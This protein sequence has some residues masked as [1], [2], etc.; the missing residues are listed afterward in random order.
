MSPAAQAQAIFLNVSNADKS[1]LALPVAASRQHLPGGVQVLKIQRPPPH[2]PLREFMREELKLAGLRLDAT[3]F[4]R[5]RMGHSLAISL[6][7]R[8]HGPKPFSD[9]G[10]SSGVADVAA[11]VGNGDTAARN[12]TGSGQSAL[13][14]DL[15]E[16]RLQGVPDGMLLNYVRWSPKGARVAFTLRSAGNA[17]DPPRGPLALYTAPVYRAVDGDVHDEFVAEAVPA[18]ARLN[19][20]FED[21]VFLDDD[22]MIAS[23]VPENHGEAPKVRCTSC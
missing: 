19:T 18:A 8:S 14:H 21:F 10:N 6:L 17:G 11:Q 7:D 9:S 16:T 13:V 22:T 23:V 1:Q 20:A 5:A 3:Q 15:P 2:P 12:G 4:S